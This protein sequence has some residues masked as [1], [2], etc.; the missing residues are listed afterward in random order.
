MKLSLFLLAFLVS[1]TKPAVPEFRQFR[2]EGFAQGTTYQITY[3]AADSLVSKAAIEAVFSRLDSSLSIYKPHSII[4]AFNQSAA[5]VAIDTH[6]KKVVE[7]SLEVYRATGGAFDITVL[8]LVNAW[9]FGVTKVESTPAKATIDSIMAC[10]GSNKL[11]LTGSMLHKQIPCVAID[12]NGIAQGYSVDVIAQLLEQKGIRNYL[13][14][15]GGEIR[16][17]GRKQPGNE[18]MKIGI[19]SPAGDPFTA[20]QIHTILVA[21]S[22]AITTSGSYRKFYESKGKQISHIIDPAT[23]ASVQNELISVTVFARDA[24]TADAYDNALMVMGLAQALRFAEQHNI[25]AYFIYRDKNNA[26]LD[27]STSSFRKLIVGGE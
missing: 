17:K 9:G 7:K 22:G 19:E 18:K 27:A 3:Y 24:M 11:Q 6:L 20:P 1:I 14:E 8:P 13:V 10:I 2:L 26:V 4:N 16:L 12:V 25:S 15:L 23:G 21:D 5:G